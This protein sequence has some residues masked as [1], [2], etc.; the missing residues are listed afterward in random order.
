V[1][2]LPRET[3]SLPATPPQDYPSRGRYAETAVSF[4]LGCT[5]LL[6]HCERNEFLDSLEAQPTSNKS[7]Q[8]PNV[9]SSSLSDRFKVVATVFQQIMTQ[10]DG[11][12][13]EENKIVAI[14]KIVLKFMMQD[15][16]LIS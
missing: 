2:R 6:R 10:L 4:A 8:A 12:E 5:G 3:F 11:A 14:T 15:G 9:N 16:Y 13:L 7:V 1:P